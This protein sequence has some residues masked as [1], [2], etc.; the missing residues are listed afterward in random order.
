[1]LRGALSCLA[2]AGLLS[3]APAA[4]GADRITVPKAGSVPSFT[5][6]RTGPASASI[7]ILLAPR[8]RGLTP[9][10]QRW[11]DRLGHDGY[12]VAVIDLY[13][14]KVFRSRRRARGRLPPALHAEARA[15]LRLLEAPGRKLITMGWGAFG[16]QQAIASALA[17]PGLVNATIIYRDHSHLVSN[18]RQ[19]TRLKGAVLAIFFR[20]K[21]RPTV[22]RFE[23]AMRLARRPLYVHFY[24]GHVRMQ[25]F[26]SDPGNTAAQLAWTETV[27]FIHDVQRYCRRCAGLYRYRYRRR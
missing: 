18:P 7:G 13:D 17:D 3:G 10:L 21:P 26:G 6:Y 1:M 5:I 2:V 14:G 4:F 15:A 11:A 27:A 8:L 9:G 16:G 20:Q 19:L 24:P 25:D 12:R 22:E 23:G